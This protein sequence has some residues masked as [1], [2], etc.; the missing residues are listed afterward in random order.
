MYI[1]KDW[2][3]A[4]NLGR[5]E[6]ALRWVKR[7]RMQYEVLPSESDVLNAFHYTD[8]NDVRVVIVGQDPYPGKDKNGK[9]YAHGLS[10]S[11]LS[12]DIPASLRNIFK[13][14]EN[15]Y[16]IKNTSPTLNGWTEQGV[17][18][19]NLV[20]TVDA[21]SPNSHKDKK[22]EYVTLNAIKAVSER[23]IPTVYMLWG[24]NA[25][26]A[27]SYIMQSKNNFILKATHPSPM[28]ANRGFFGC[29][30]FRKCNKFLKRNGLEEIIWDTRG[31]PF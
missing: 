13:E 24:K 19:L 27:E 20:L 16:G 29:D 4:L 23:D 5:L 15:E 21:G 30:H 25:Q 28:S 17:L 10:F 3:N 9:Y 2:D 22:W 14:I 11:T 18:L 8:F 26:E 7:R 12:D 31:Y 1:S 6:V